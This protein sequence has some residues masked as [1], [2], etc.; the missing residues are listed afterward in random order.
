M[1]Y[2]K[3][4]AG[5]RY[6]DLMEKIK[7]QLGFDAMNELDEVVGARL[8]EA[9]DQVSLPVRVD[10]LEGEVAGLREDAQALLDQVQQLARI[11]ATVGTVTKM[12]WPPPEREPEEE[13]AA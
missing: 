8:A 13:D 11:L 2:I 4:E 7:E 3:T 10:K 6:D 12:A 5:E 9:Q 1:R